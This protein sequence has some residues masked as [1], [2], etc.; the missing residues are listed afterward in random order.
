MAATKGDG[1][2]GSLDPTAEVT[3]ELE[4]QG[5][6]RIPHLQHHTSGRAAFVQ[7]RPHIGTPYRDF[8]RDQGCPLGLV[9]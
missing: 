4:P 2:N 8:L 7:G 6:R 3:G 1:T 9:G 5:I